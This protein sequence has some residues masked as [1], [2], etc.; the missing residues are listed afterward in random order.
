MQPP[1]VCVCVC[2]C[3][4]G[5]EEV[6]QLCIQLRDREGRVALLHAPAQVLGEQEPAWGQGSGAKEEA[7][8]LGVSVCARWRGC[9]EREWYIYVERERV[10]VCGCV[11]VCVCVSLGMRK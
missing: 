1:R 2:V 8:K 3:L 11:C 10:C 4:P 9:A 7:V 5:D 6:V